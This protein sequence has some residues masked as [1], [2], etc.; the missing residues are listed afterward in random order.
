MRTFR[1]TVRLAEPL[2]RFRVAHLTDM[3]FG[4]V[5]PLAVQE[6]AVAAVNVAAPDLVVITGDFVCH[7]QAYLDQ[8][9]HVL[10]KRRAPA[11]GV[12][13]NHADW[14]GAD[15]VRH[16]LKKANVH[17]LSNAHTT[18]EV[19]GERLQLVGLDDA[20]TGHAD[21]GRALQGLRKDLD[22]DRRQHSVTRPASAPRPPA[23][24]APPR[25]C[26][27]RAP[28]ACTAASSR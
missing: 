22:Q 5:T 13:G 12:V 16:G 4:R 6:A 19:R 28:R 23:R 15:E 2:D 25:T 8:M 26:A 1:G 24:S 7:S 18:I 27:A 9:A 10:G 17:L 20:Y 11:F 3:H 21:R 14:S